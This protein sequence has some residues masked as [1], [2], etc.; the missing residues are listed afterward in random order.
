MLLAVGHVESVPEE[1]VPV[2]LGAVDG[3]LLAAFEQGIHVLGRDGGGVR[4]SLQGFEA[5]RGQ[6]HLLLHQIGLPLDGS[7]GKKRD[8]AGDDINADEAPIRGVSWPESLFPV[9]RLLLGFVM[10]VFPFMALEYGSRGWRAGR[11]SGALAILL[12]VA[13]IVLLA[14]PLPWDLRAYHRC[15][16]GGGGAEHD[17]YRQT[18]QHSAQ[19]YQAREASYGG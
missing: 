11:W 8:Q 3:Q 10:L 14:A 18:L 1:R 16:Q 13:G 5:F 7:Q 12:I 9:A 6:R 19:H 4:A 17:G 2:W 15:V